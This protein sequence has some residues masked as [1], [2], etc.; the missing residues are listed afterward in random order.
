MTRRIAICHL[1]LRGSRWMPVSVNRNLGHKDSCA[2]GG[3]V[4]SAVLCAVIGGD[5]VA[6]WTENAGFMVRGVRADG[7]LPPPDFRPPPLAL[8]A[9][10]FDTPAAAAGGSGI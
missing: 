9:R 7:T 3:A 2:P 1:L 4:I 10:D 6:G 8:G 5:A